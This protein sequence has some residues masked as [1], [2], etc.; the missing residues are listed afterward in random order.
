VFV[1]NLGRWKRPKCP[2]IHEC[3]NKIQY[4]HTM[5][6]YSNLK[7]KEI[8]IYVTTWMNIANIMLSE[9]SQTQ[10]DEYYVLSSGS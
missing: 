8:L 5:E 3:I 4:I 9:I 7:M 1:V 6:Y 2:S 10:K